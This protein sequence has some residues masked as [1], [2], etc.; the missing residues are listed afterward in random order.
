MNNSNTTQNKA[1]QERQQKRL[2]AES[3]LID[4]LRELGY[5]IFDFAIEDFGL[6]GEETGRTLREYAQ[7]YHSECQTDKA[8]SRRDKQEAMD[9]WSEEQAHYD[10]MYN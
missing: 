10:N 1:F 9:N 8:E 3:T 6:T 7:D 2:E 4:M 5:D